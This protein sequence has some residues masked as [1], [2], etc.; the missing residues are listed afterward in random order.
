MPVPFISR[1]IDVFGQ[2]FLIL[3]IVG[4][5]KPVRITSTSHPLVFISFIN[6]LVNVGLG[7]K[8]PTSRLT[9]GG[10]NP[11]LPGRDVLSGTF[12]AS[13][14]VPSFGNRKHSETEDKRPNA[15]KNPRAWERPP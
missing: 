8:Y 12:C 15:W 5:E 1:H 10:K 11:S 13:S 7:L 2:A 9:V 14:R 3:L 4:W 6:A